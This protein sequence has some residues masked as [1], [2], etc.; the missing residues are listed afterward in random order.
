M[1]ILKILILF[2]NNNFEN[3]KNLENIN[4]FRVSKIYIF[5]FKNRNVN[6]V[7]KKKY[8]CPNFE[9]ILFLS[10]LHVQK[11]F[12]D[13]TYYC[14]II[15]IFAHFEILR[16]KIVIFSIF[17]FYIFIFSTF[18][19]WIFGFSDS[20]FPD[21]QI[22]RFHIQILR[23]QILRL[24]LYFQ[25]L[26]HFCNLYPWICI[27]CCCWKVVSLNCASYWTIRVVKY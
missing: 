9:D 16:F 6:F 22:L 24:S 4:F 10:L 25:I 7:L 1:K 2:F 14:D 13:L 20:W 21:S 3:I 19:S 26:K 11:Y 27:F 17:K 23:S 5:C 12:C 8:V 15:K 18:I